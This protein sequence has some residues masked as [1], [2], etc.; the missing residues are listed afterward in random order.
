MG[1]FGMQH[2]SL[3]VSCACRYAHVYGPVQP[4]HKCCGHSLGEVKVFPVAA[5]WKSPEPDNTCIGLNTYI[6]MYAMCMSTVCRRTC[7][8]P[9]KRYTMVTTVAEEEGLRD[10]A[11]QLTSFLIR[12]SSFL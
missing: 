5:L 8:L 7:I 6:Y 10:G 2:A 3:D 9:Y 11:K 1:L 4:I 12:G